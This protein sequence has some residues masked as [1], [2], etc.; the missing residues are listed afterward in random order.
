MDCF[1]FPLFTLNILKPKRCFLSEE[2]IKRVISTEHLFFK[3][4][5][6]HLLL[7]LASLMD[8]WLGCAHPRCSVFWLTQSQ[9]IATCIQSL[10]PDNVTW[11]KSRYATISTGLACIL[12]K[13]D[14][15]GCV[16]QNVTIL[17]IPHT[18]ISNFTYILL[19]SQLAQIHFVHFISH[20][21][22]LTN[23]S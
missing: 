7:L 8:H 4:A 17:G 5:G 2:I 14:Y 19:E 22:V 11:N 1:S 23:L 12:M 18:T 6:E 9:L 21:S 16:Q 15:T 10:L 13:G 3:A 20:Y